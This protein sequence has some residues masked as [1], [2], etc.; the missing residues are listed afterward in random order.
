MPAQV[1]W[2][3]AIAVLLGCDERDR[4][5]FPNADDMV[6][7]ISTI[8]PPATD[9]VLTEG[10][11][12]VLGGRAVDSSGVDSVFFEL[13]GADFTYRPL[14]GAGADS[15]SFGLNI[16]TVGFGGQTITVQVFGVDMLGNRGA[17]VAR[18]L[19]IE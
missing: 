19:T 16:P 3:V 10:D 18:R 4:L 2:G 12:F 6:G 7:P 11:L 17:T 13:E 14:A 15:V 1:R 5:T 8:E 9:T